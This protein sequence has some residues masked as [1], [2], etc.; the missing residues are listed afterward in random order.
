MRK[1][2]VLKLFLLTSALCSLILATIFIGQ[3]MFFK[4]FYV[5]RKTDE[6]K[7]N[8]SSFKQSYVKNGK[9]TKAIIELKDRFYEDHNSWITILDENGLIQGENEFSFI[10][11][12]DFANYYGKA[13][14]EVPIKKFSVPLYN[15]MNIND[16]WNEP[17][18]LKEGMYVNIYGYKR[19]ETF[20]PVEIVSTSM[21]ES[22]ENNVLKK[23]FNEYLG[24]L[25]KSVTDNQNQAPPRI[26]ADENYFTT[27]V[28][29]KVNV[30]DF[31]SVSKSL[32][33]NALFTK[34]I[35]ELQAE[36]LSDTHS[37]G[38]LTG[39]SA[40]MVRDFTDNGIK[41]RLLIQPF[42]NVEGKTEYIFT[43]TS[44][45]PLDEAVGMMKD[46]YVYLI[47]FVLLL[48]L[49]AAFYYS[50]K[51]ARPLLQINRT[52]QKIAN[53]DFSEKL[54]ITSND[55]IGAISENIN[56]LSE[57][58]QTHIDQLKQDIE[59]ER[60]LE[61]TRKQ[62][63]S[64]V[65]HELKTPLSVM[66][67]C[68]SI[69]KDGVASHKKDYYFAAMEKEV[70]K[71]DQ[72]IVDMLE[73]AKLES[74][75]FKIKLESFYINELLAYICKTLAPEMEKKDL[76]LTMNLL[77]VKVMADEL[78]IEQVL[79]NFMMNAIRHSP[80]GEKIFVTVAEENERVKIS[81]ENTGVLIP[82]SDL[83]KVWERFYRSDPSR[84]RSQVQGGTGL[85]LSISKNI[86]LMHETEFGVYNTK[87]G[88]LFY[89]YLMKME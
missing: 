10:V 14:S 3:T 36:I 25:N 19:G 48:V 13:P 84:Q 20:I 64:G 75:T 63:I 65:S 7:K 5:E 86:L 37:S 66:Q 40:F 54:P 50:K 34:K 60:Q 51:I 17:T 28:I 83:N 69:L 87:K 29:E 43:M 30:P 27:G 57:T 1:G 45:Q 67:S 12:N 35:N 82:A 8:M 31:G 71:M 16:F 18:R 72:L 74:G 79:T 73:L 88:V 55:E 85:G 68:I 49:L 70:G 53:L 26:H 46:Y 62:F 11:S 2:I 61:N 4:G 56:I 22:I 42:K 24:Q 44:L 77:Q 9:N 15:S 41:Y 59:K 89:F 39:D 76:Q 38:N 58:L 81:I 47:L 6:L 33:A 52:T 21:L 78:R 32:T 80:D 23:T